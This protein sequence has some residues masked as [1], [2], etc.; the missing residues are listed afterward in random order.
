M[1]VTPEIKPTDVVVALRKLTSVE[2]AAIG[3]GPSA[4]CFVD[5]WKRRSSTRHGYELST[6][7][8]RA[9]ER[10]LLPPVARL[11]PCRR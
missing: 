4:D 1:C 3:V 5:Q 6:G 8:W 11:S 7:V 9:K 2:I 10:A